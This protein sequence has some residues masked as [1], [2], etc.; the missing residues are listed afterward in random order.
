M[1][2]SPAAVEPRVLVLLSSHGVDDHSDYAVELARGHV[3]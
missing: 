1:I 2:E 3:L